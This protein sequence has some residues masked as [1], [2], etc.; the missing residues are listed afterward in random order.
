VWGPHL[1]L[2][3]SR[4]RSCCTVL[5]APAKER[6]EGSLATSEW[7]GSLGLLDDKISLT[8]ILC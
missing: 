8:G 7:S 4:S 3:S 2:T 6:L 1:A 5:K